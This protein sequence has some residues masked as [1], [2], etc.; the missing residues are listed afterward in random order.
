M[1]NPLADHSTD[2]SHG[3]DSLR[4]VVDLP[5]SCQIPHSFIHCQAKWT[6]RYMTQNFTSNALFLVLALTNEYKPGESTF[7]LGETTAILT[8]SSSQF[9]ENLIHNVHNIDIE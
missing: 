4:L 8:K 3:T 6:T 5:G 7:S 2:E 9:L 1:L